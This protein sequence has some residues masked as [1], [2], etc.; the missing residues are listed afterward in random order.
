MPIGRRGPAPYETVDRR[1]FEIYFGQDWP[2]FSPALDK[3]LAKTRRV[4]SFSWALVLF[5]VPWLLYRRMWRD[6]LGYFAI[7][8]AAQVMGILNIGGLAATMGLGL[9]LRSYAVEHAARKIAGVLRG[10]E[11]DP[12]ASVAAAG[13]VSEL[14]AFVGSIGYAAVIDLSVWSVFDVSPWDRRALGLLVI[15][16][17]VAAVACSMTLGYLRRRAELGDPRRKG[18]WPVVLVGTLL[19]TASLASIFAAVAPIWGAED[20]VLDSVLAIAIVMAIPALIIAAVAHLVTRQPSYSFAAA[21]AGTVG[22]GGMMYLG[23]LRDPERVAT[24]AEPGGVV[25]L[26]FALLLLLGSLGLV[27]LKTEPRGKTLDT[28]R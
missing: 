27:A 19:L 26:G 28:H 23:F 2:L 16:A 25:L 11:P 5:P 7:V 18:D 22:W 6:G 10:N 9:W 13:G 12:R 8:V 4:V 15:L 21:A 14:G 24:A 1:W 3:M 17:T 20:P